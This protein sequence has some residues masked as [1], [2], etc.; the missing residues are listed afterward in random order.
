MSI[1]S[2]RNRID[3]MVGKYDKSIQDELY[4]RIENYKRFANIEYIDDHMISYVVYNE[5]E[6]IL[7]EKTKGKAHIMFGGFK[8]IIIMVFVAVAFLATQLKAEVV[9]DYIDMASCNKQDKKYYSVCWDDKNNVP[10]SGWS[11]IDGSLI[12]KGNTK[13]R[14]SFYKDQVLKTMAPVDI[15]MPDERGHTFANDNDNDYN[16]EA[17][18]STYNMI[19]ITPQDGKFNTGLWRKIESR[20][21]N[22]ARK[23]GEVE[24]ITIVEYDGT[25]KNNFLYPKSY[26]R[27]YLAEDVSECYKVPNI[28]PEFKNI[29]QYKVD[30]VDLLIHK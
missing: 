13:K 12:D 21:N 15:Q 9:S 6:K 24:A 23:I 25:T 4:S 26:T 11:L 3:R 14:P 7:M 20:G 28:V 8:T 10:V 5:M 16:S 22:L 1:M 27:I 30:C 2:E 17:L 29:N 18:K 19:N